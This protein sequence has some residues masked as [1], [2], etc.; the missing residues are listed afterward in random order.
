[1][2]FLRI[3]VLLLTIVC[4][5]FLSACLVSSTPPSNQ[6]HQYRS[7]MKD[8]MGRQLYVFLPDLRLV[9]MTERQEKCL[10][11]TDDWLINRKVDGFDQPIPH[12]TSYAER[13]MLADTVESSHE[14]TMSFVLESMNI[15]IQSSKGRSITIEKERTFQKTYGPILVNPG[16]K[17]RLIAHLVTYIEEGVF[18]GDLYRQESLLLGHKWKLVKEDVGFGHWKRSREDLFFE[19]ETKPVEANE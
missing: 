1:M 11:W 9:K 12:Q 6:D 8:E 2:K 16:F 19:F 3:F 14:W 18:Q 4:T 15:G 17:S 7:V 5:A 10:Q 13:K